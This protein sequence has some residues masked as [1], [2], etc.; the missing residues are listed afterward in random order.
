MKNRT[1]LRNGDRL[2]GLRGELPLSEIEGYTTHK[3]WMFK[4]VALGGVSE[5]EDSVPLRS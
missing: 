1:M 3:V 5:R 4:G 2:W